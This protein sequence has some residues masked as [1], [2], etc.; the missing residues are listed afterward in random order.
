MNVNDL[1][2]IALEFVMILDCH[3]MDKYQLQTEALV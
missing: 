1:M 3:P 2:L